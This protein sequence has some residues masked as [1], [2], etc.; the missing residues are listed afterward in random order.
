MMIKTE[1]LDQLKKGL[2]G[3]PEDDITR[4]IEF[5]SEMIDDRV[6]DGKTEQEAVADIGTVKEAVA[7]ILSEI[8]MSKLIKEKAKKKRKFNAWEIVLLALGSPIW[9]SLIVAAFAVV[10]S[11]YAVIWSVVASLWAVFAALI[12]GAVGGVGS[13]VVFICT[14]NLLPGIAMIGASLVCAGLSIFMFFG[15]KETTKGIVI[16]TKKIALFIK[17]SFVKKEVA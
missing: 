2:L 17:K 13:G 15:C 14:D 9:L 16:L 4:S 3:L 12:G 8:P 1:F 6:E 11:V 7:Q 5:Y 10:I